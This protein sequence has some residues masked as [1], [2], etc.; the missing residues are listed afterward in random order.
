[1]S[2]TKSPEVDKAEVA[3]KLIGL[4]DTPEGIAEA[5]Q[6]LKD[7]PDLAKE[8]EADGEAFIKKYTAEKVEKPAQPEEELIELGK[9]PKKLLRSYNSIE[10]MSKGSEHKDE[11]IDFFKSKRVPELETENGSLRNENL[12]LKRQLEEYNRTKQ[13]QQAQPVDK[14][15]QDVT[16]VDEIGDLLDEENQKRAISLIKNLVQSNKNLAEEL[17]QVKNKVSTVDSVMEAD[18]LDKRRKQEI[19]DNE[20]QL[21]AT[22]AAN[23]HIFGTSRPI[24][25]VDADYHSFLANGAR[26]LGYDG[27]VYDANGAYTEG[28]KAAFNAYHDPNGAE[29]K[30]KLAAMGVEFPADYNALLVRDEISKV[31]ER[32]GIYD[33]AS[34]THKPMPW[35]EATALYEVQNGLVDKRIKDAIKTGAEVHAKAVSN[36]Q[37]FAKE[38][39][40]KEGTPA[41]LTT[42]IELIGKMVTDYTK[43]VRDKKLTREQIE[44]KQIELRAILKH[45]G[46]EEAEIEALLKVQT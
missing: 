37:S 1:M 23:T 34:N 2:D 4:T 22:R 18:L 43:G 33:S 29:F 17:G 46:L 16:D 36:R 45:N 39:T 26:L 15:V 10:E 12:S 24:S 7:N 3:R 38:V 8:V 9:V 21:E 6:I 41:Q 5:Q 14:I 32:Y 20:A 30:T 13:S 44:N 27:T 19:A 35:K 42:D 40:P 28:A 31:R 25:A 11:V